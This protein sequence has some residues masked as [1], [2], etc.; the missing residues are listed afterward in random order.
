MTKKELLFE[1]MFDYDGKPNE[2]YFEMVVGDHWHNNELQ[3]YTNSPKNCFVGEGTLNLVA[4]LNEDKCKYQSARLTTKNKVHFQYGRFVV[5]AKMPKGRGSWPAV[6]FLGVEDEF[7]GWPKRG[8]IDLLEFAGHKKDRVTCAIHTSTYNHRDNSDLG[9]HYELKDADDN[10]HD[11]ILEWTKDYLSFQVDYEEYFRIEK[12]ETDTT[13]EF[14]FNKPYHMIINL[15]VGGMYGKEV[16]DED[17]PY[18][19][20]IASIRV[21]QIN[22]EAKVI[23][24]NQK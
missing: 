7:E 3:C 1:E 16:F 18:H 2:D 20:E 6:W 11:Y 4:T 8:E 12:K 10:F 9:G 23:K 15:A 5:R 17:L 21:F 19:F 13:N 24:I 14:P 22:N